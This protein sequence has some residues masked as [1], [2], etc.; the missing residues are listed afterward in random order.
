MTNEL[1]SEPDSAQILLSPEAAIVLFELLSRWSIKSNAPTP[2]ASC[3]E[4]TA[5]GAVLVGLLAD[6]EVQLSAP[7][8]ADYPQTLKVARDR[9]KDDWS[10]HTLRG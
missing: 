3:F 8:C 2:D 1:N 9:L 7:F 4:S 6:L 5:E 10:Y